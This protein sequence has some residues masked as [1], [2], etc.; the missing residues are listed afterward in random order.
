M[1]DDGG[2]R[3]SR[4]GRTFQRST[5][6]CPDDNSV[7]FLAGRTFPVLVPD[8]FFGFLERIWVKP[9]DAQLSNR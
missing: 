1:S 6:P 2:L 5:V 9:D 3:R 4:F 8:A 7:S